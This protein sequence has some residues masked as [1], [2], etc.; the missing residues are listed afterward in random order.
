MW[1]DLFKLM[2]EGFDINIKVKNLRWY[3]IALVCL[4]TI[5]NYLSRSSLSIAAPQVMSDLNFTE[6]EYSWIVSAFQICYT[7]AQP[8]AGYIIDMIGLKVGFFIFAIAWSLFNM[9]HAFA[10]GWVSLAFLRGGM[11]L[12]E[13]AAIPAGMKASAEW[14]PAKERGIAGG[15]FNAGTSVGAML[16]PP[17]VVWAMLTFENS[18][19]GTEMAFIITGG[20]GILFAITWYLIYRSPA[21]HSWLTKKELDY[22]EQGQEKHLVANDGKPAIKEILKQRNF[23]GLA[24]ARFLAD[25]AWGTLSFWMPLYLTSVMHLPLKEIAMFAW[26]PFLAADFGCVAGGFMAKFFMEKLHMTTLNARRTSFTI[27]AILMLAIGFVSIVKDPY[28][29]IALMSVGGFAHQ[30][31]STVVITMS[32]DLFKKNEVAT[33]VGLAGSAAWIGQLSFTLVLGALVAIIGYGPFFISLSIFDVIGAVVLW[34]LLKEPASQTVAHCQM[35]KATA[36][37]Y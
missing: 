7:I 22:I 29:A 12:T 6:K 34:V 15:L 35:K 30:T 36:A 27:G 19:L 28:V 20:V 31:L 3:I 11:G 26:L 32:A 2:V 1:P 8:I 21:K 9:A 16:A 14:F 10:G 5:V 37:A 33:V 25:P 17:L 23:W 13:A 24:I 18:G 4:G